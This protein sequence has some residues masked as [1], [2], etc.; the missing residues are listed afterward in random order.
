MTPRE[1]TIQRVHAQ[2]WATFRQ[3]QREIMAAIWRNRFVAIL[4]ARQVVGKTTIVAYSG[5]TLAQGVEVD[6]R[7]L[8]PDHVNVISKSE[9][10][11]RDFVGRA[12]Q[13]LAAYRLGVSRGRRRQDAMTDPDL[14]SLS[15]IR[16]ATGRELVAHSG[17][18]DA[19]QGMRGHILVDE[20]AA[21]RHRPEWIFSQA[22]ATTAASSARKFVMIGNASV[23]G[24][25]WHKFWESDEPEWCERRAGF[26]MLRYTV[27]DVFGGILPPDIMQIKRAMAP[28][29]W[30]RW[31]ECEFVAGHK[32]A[33]LPEVI[34]ATA[35]GNPRC[36]GGQVVIGIDPGQN[37]NPTGIV[38]ARVGSFSCH[39]IL[40][41][42]WHGPTHQS[43]ASLDESWM[44]AQTTK[45][46]ALVAKHRPTRIICDFSNFA[47]TLGKALQTEFGPLVE[48]IATTRDT[49]QRR[50]GA[51]L[52]MLTD[53]A[54]SIPPG[55]EGDD[56]RDDLARLEIDESRRGNSKFYESGILHLPS[57]PDDNG[58][59]VRHC[60]IADA[61][62]LCCEYVHTPR[63]GDF[64]L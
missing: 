56:L 46:R 14:G 59:H 64:V 57:S 21:N 8:A 54:I 61:L 15:R 31:F 7:T 48:L 53:A 6:G 47:A 11:S 4:G 1:R 52:G 39:V 26:T 35:L 36:T 19:V 58:V 29:D 60:D 63:G 62:L 30:R 3:S 49:R 38:V 5:L 23:R 45:I 18:P 24:D 17:N 51:L 10:H 41:E 33:L 9:K 12:T 42:Y 40:S 43:A 13:M 34:E 25:W 32:K 20:I 28:A 2:Y 16:M 37:R 44:L 55:A 22:I 27:D 50:W